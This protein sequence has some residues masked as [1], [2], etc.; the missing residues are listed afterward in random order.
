MKATKDIIARN[1]HINK[2]MKLKEGWQSFVILAIL[3]VVLVITF[4]RA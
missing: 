2:T 3:I 4:I 1:F